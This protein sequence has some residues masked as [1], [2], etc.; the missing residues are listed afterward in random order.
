VC[1]PELGIA[2]ELGDIGRAAFV[3][4][5]TAA[6]RQYWHSGSMEGHPRALLNSR[7]IPRGMCLHELPERVVG[8]TMLA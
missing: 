7:G 1:S 2:F 5:H 4:L 6:Y 8:L 3:T